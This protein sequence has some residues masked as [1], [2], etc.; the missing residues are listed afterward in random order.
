MRI[1]RALI[2]FSI[3]IALLLASIGIAFADTGF[4]SVGSFSSTYSAG[5]L[6]T[7]FTLVAG[8]GIYDWAGYDWPEVPVSVEV[9]RRGI[10]DPCGTETHVA[11]FS[12]NQQGVPLVTGD[13]MDASV[14]ANTTYQYLAY[15]ID[16]QAARM[17]PVAMIGFASTGIGLL[18]HGTLSNVA[19]CGVSGIW[20]AISCNNECAGS[21][22]LDSAPAEALPYFNTTTTLAIYG[23]VAGLSPAFC[24][25][26]EPAFKI[27]SV[28]ERSCVTAVEPV[29][30]GAVKAM[31]K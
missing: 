20:R 14:Q 23:E 5:A 28:V 6:H 4:F 25:V 16:G 30:W 12:W 7:Q 3:V 11:Y 17:A 13:I 1:K 27:T 21:L 29:T 18:C 8:Y 19:D 2:A 31:Y 10:S 24:N 26:V 15:G 22:Y 9:V